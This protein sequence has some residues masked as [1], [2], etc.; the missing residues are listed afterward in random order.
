MIFYGRR[1]VGRSFFG[2]WRVDN[3][4]LTG[5]KAAAP[6]AFSILSL[7][8]CSPPPP[9]VSGDTYC[10]RTSHLDVTTFQEEAMA[11]DPG[12][13]RPLAVQILDANTIRAKNCS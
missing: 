8:A 13:F 11:K 5:V 7:A 1:I 6:I 2:R 12:T 10:A 4:N 9:V 3:I